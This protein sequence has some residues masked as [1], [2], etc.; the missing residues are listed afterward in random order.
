MGLFGLFGK[1][2]GKAAPAE[3]AE[4]GSFLEDYAGRV[5]KLLERL[6]ERLE[7][8]DRENICQRVA[9]YIQSHV[10][11]DM[12]RG[13]LAR[14]FG[15]SPEYLSHLFKQAMGISLVSFITREKLLYCRRMFDITS[16]SV[17]AAAEKVGYTNFSYFAKLFKKEFGC[18][19]QQYKEG[20]GHR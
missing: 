9:A 19:P 12:D 3:K 7:K 2:A 15:L 17:H 14:R 10:E 13:M 4:E 5:R 20:R 11:E 18:T 6:G 8:G 1:K 16:C